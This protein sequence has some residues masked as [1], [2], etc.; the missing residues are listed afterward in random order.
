MRSSAVVADDGLDVHSA[1]AI[2]DW[3]MHIACIKGY[4][5]FCKCCLTLFRFGTIIMLFQRLRS[6]YIYTLK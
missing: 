3:S 1:Q 2:V 4:V 6:I 5:P